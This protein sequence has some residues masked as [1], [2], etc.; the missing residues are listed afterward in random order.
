MAVLGEPIPEQEKFD[1]LDVSIRR[2]D[3]ILIK[4]GF[5]MQ[6]AVSVSLNILYM[7]KYKKSDTANWVK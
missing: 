1:E 2:E 6:H 4:L 7:D 5:L 3:C